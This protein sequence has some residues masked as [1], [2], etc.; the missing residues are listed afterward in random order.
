MQE[1]TKEIIDQTNGSFGCG[2]CEGANPMLLTEGYYIAQSF[3]P[4]QNVISKIALCLKKSGT[5]P[6]DMK[7]NSIY[8]RKPRW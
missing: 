4:S 6:T 5:P 1:N 2:G 7:I 3:T 8:K